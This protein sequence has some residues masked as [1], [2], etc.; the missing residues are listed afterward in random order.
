MKDIVA[1]EMIENVDVLKQD[2]E[3]Y[4]SSQ[5]NPDELAATRLDEIASNME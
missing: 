5:M 2:F 4:L 1:N 3:N